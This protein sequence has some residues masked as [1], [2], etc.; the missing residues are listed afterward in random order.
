MGHFP[1]KRNHNV[2]LRKGP[3][4]VYC[5]HAHLVF[6]T[7]E[8]R[9]AL[10]E[11]AIADLSY[12]FARVCRNFEAEL[13]ECNGG[14]DHVHLLIAYPPQLALSE[15][16]SRL[17]G[18]SSRLLLDWRPEVR[19]RYEDGSLWSPSYFVC[20]CGG[21]PLPIITRYIRAQ[22]DPPS[23]RLPHNPERRGHP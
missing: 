21:A 13:M 8:R 11:P 5:L 15:L 18:V 9:D 2:P 6:V 10:S 14:D 12:I 7:R 3:H 17:K 19:G 1:T 22:R 16:V 4:V 20:A 23:R